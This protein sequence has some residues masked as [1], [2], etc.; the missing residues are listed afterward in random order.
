[1]SWNIE[2]KLH[3]ADPWEVVKHAFPSV[4]AAADKVRQL[5]GWQSFRWKYRIVPMVE[6]KPA[7]LSAEMLGEEDRAH[8]WNLRRLAMRYETP[9][10]G[11]LD[12]PC[13]VWADRLLGSADKGGE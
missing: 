12:P 5:E 1:M 8:L 6:P 9:M 10:T 13:V 7:A 4:Q 3:A 11:K 2:R